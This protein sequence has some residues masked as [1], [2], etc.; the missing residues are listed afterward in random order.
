M[1]IG[2]HLTAVANAKCER[3]VAP[4]EIFKFIAR[5]CIEQNRFCPAF[6]CAQHVTIGKSAAR[7]KALEIAQRDAAS[8]DVAHVYINRGE[9]CLGERVRHFKLTIHALLA[10]YR[11]LRPYASSDERCGDVLGGIERQL[12][13]QTRIS[14]LQNPVKLLLGR[15]RI[16]PE[17]LND[18]TGLA[19]CALKVNTFFQQQRFGSSN[20]A[21]FIACV[22]VPDYM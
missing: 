6:A 14:C 16:V 17:R 3:I 19:P 9:S 13:V 2:H 10:K 4:E 22:Q 7:G 21:T 8:D 15:L 11:N 1:Q 5:S 20:D 12:C 18:V